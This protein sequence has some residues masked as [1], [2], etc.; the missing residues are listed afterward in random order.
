MKTTFPQS[1]NA[2]AF[3][4]SGPQRAALALATVLAAATGAAAAQA[5]IVKIEPGTIESF[6][7]VHL[8][9][10]LEGQNTAYHVTHRTRLY[11]HGQPA[12]TLELKPGTELSGIAERQ[13]DGEIDLT[14]VFLT[15]P[16]PQMTRIEEARIASFDRV[17]MEVKLAGRDKEYAVT[18]HTRFFENGEPVTTSA[19]QPGAT[20]SGSLERLPD[21]QRELE[22]VY[23]EPPHTPVVTQR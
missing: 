3:T 5:E 21:G 22:R 17:H 14:R 1:P 11:E 16:K 4:K 7:R 10:K 8:D 23:L 19:L 12:T 15:L 2:R 18:H 6:D 9:V 13:P 20:I